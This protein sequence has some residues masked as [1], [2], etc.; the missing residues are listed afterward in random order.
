MPRSDHHAAALSGRRIDAAA[1]APRVMR[2][3]KYVAI[4]GSENGRRLIAALLRHSEPAA[5][6]KR[7]ALKLFREV[8]G[9]RRKGEMVGKVARAP[10]W[11]VKRFRLVAEHP[12]AFCRH[13]R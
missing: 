5:D 2:I 9:L 12:D 6:L 10:Q 13:G 3:V 11:L 7:W 1:R 4:V 8:S